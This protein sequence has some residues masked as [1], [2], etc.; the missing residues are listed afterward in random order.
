ML[1]NI[2]F[3]YS[4]RSLL[5]PKKDRSQQPFRADIFSPNLTKNFNFSPI[6]IINLRRIFTARCYYI[7]YASS[8]IWVIRFGQFR[9]WRVTRHTKW[10]LF[11]Y[12]GVRIFNGGRGDA[13]LSLGWDHIKNVICWR[14]DSIILNTS[15]SDPRAASIWTNDDAGIKSLRVEEMIFSEFSALRRILIQGVKRGGVKTTFSGSFVV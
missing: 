9:A 1:R 4:R 8:S 5:N 7:G 3:F 11:L 14:D 6:M 13:S 10:S 12:G 2:R 15:L